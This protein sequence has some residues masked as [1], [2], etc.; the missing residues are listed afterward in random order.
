MEKDDP[1]QSFRKCLIICPQLDFAVWWIVHL[2]S[3][4]AI[5]PT[6]WMLQ[7][8]HFMKSTETRAEISWIIRSHMAK[9]NE[10]NL[11][12][13]TLFTPLWS[14]KLF[15][16]ALIKL[17]EAPNPKMLHSWTH[18]KGFSKLLRAICLTV[19]NKILKFL[20]KLTRFGGV[21]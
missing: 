14:G 7:V 11:S 12:I 17:S 3:G 20:Q 18:R 19:I 1:T 6:Y 10:W 2:C 5:S 13:P 21:N 4:R 8:L 9:C 15:V 16:W